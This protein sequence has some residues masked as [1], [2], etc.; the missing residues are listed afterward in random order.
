MITSA[1]GKIF[2]LGSG[3][4]F[5]DKGVREKVDYVGDETCVC[6]EDAVCWV[7]KRSDIESVIGDVKRLG[8][9]IPFKPSALDSSITLKDIK[10]HR[11]LGMGMSFRH[12][13]ASSV[14]NLE[15]S[16]ISVCLLLLRCLW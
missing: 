10:K 7:L 14:L 2:F 5:G 13:S 16:D 1:D 11:I 6:E 3:D 9:S 4:Y 12:S 15:L 8:K